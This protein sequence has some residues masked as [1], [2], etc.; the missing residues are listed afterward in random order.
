MKYELLG[1]LRVT[2]EKG[3][4]FI[5]ARK[6]Q[7]LLA[8][9]LI[10]SDHLVP[11]DQLIAEIWGEQVPRRAMAGLHVYVSQ[12][13]KFLHRP[14]RM[15]SPIVTQSPG[16]VLHPGS[17]EL[18]HQTF[19]RLV[20]RGRGH[21][22]EGWQE[23]AM[24]DFRQALELWRGPALG[25]HRPGPIIEGFATWLT[26]TRLDCVELLIDAQL[27]AGQHREPIGWL[28]SLTA[29]HPLR[30]TFHRQ[31]MLALYRSERQADALKAYQVAY[32]TLSDE[33]GV[34][35]S[36]TLQDLQLAILHADDRLDRRIA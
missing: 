3:S 14:G 31:L 16:Y 17:D 10:R 36:R 13:R 21:L 25:D 8:V 30:E 9:L 34:R 6:I 28:Y 19:L 2:D 15:S 23:R 7:T 5:S 24:A 32:R 33:L 18:D 22:R 1:P 35:P 11:V 26:E 20:E 12:L 29:E 4:S 27:A